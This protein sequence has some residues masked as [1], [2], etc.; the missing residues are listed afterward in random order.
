MLFMALDRFVEAAQNIGVLHCSSSSTLCSSLLL[1]A[2]LSGFLETVN[3]PS[4][5]RRLEALSFRK[6]DKERFD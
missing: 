6:I 3:S 4:F 1:F 5:V 2:I